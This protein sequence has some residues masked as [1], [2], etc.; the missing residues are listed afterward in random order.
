MANMFNKSTNIGGAFKA[1]SMTLTFAGVGAGYLINQ[2]TANYKVD[3]TRLRELGSNKVYYVEGDSQGQLGLGQVVGPGKSITTLMQKYGDACLVAE[4]VI[5]LSFVSGGYCGAGTPITGGGAPDLTF[6]QVLLNQYKITSQ[7]A[8][9]MTTSG[10]IQGMFESLETSDGTPTT[11]AS[12]MQTAASGV[13]KK[14]DYASKVLNS[15]QVL[16]DKVANT[17][18]SVE[19]LLA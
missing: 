6:N 5:T 11:R 2:V 10:D 12:A 14:I 9:A 1:N 18:A 4:N 15:G 16:Q 19:S 8:N 17:V 7:V 13:M 3:V